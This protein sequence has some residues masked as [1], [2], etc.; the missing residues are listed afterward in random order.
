MGDD[1]IGTILYLDNGWMTV[2]L[3]TKER[4]TF[5]TEDPWVAADAEMAAAYLSYCAYCGTYDVEGDAVLHRID[6]CSIPHWVG[7]VQ[8][9]HFQ[10][11][12]DTLTLRTDPYELGGHTVVSTL[13]WK[14]VDG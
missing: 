1:A 10:R 12:G 14:R 11:T 6:M 7:S 4:P 8:V 9:R 13:S 3:S 2:H 5:P